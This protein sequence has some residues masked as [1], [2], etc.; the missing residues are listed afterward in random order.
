MDEIVSEKKKLEEI[1]MKLDETKT[2][3][4][5]FR[6]KWKNQK[7]EAPRGTKK[8]I[9]YLGMRMN[10]KLDWKNHIKY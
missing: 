6:M 10:K 4:C 5:I 7:E 2:E 9:T 1:G 3:A 8:K